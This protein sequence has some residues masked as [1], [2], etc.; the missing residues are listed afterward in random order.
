MKT[1][2][3]MLSL[4]FVSASGWAFPISKNYAE[5]QKFMRDLVSQNP[6]TTQLFTLAQSDSGEMIEGLRIGN[7]PTNNLLV[8]THHGNEY[9]S[10]E[11]AKGFALSLAASPIQ[12]QT[13][14]IIPVLNISGYNARNRYEKGQDPNRD[15]PGPCGTNGPFKLKSTAA[16][17]KFI[18]DKAIIASATLHTYS[19]AVV[20]PWGISTHDLSTPYD[21]LFKGLVKAATIESGYQTGNNTEVMYPADGTFED[22]AFWKTGAWSLLWEV[23]YTHTPSQQQVDDIVKLN[24]PGLRRVFEQTPLARAEKH[25]FTGKCDTAMPK[26]IRLE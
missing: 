26:R 6:S 13:V 10:T 23:G 1:V 25:E 17:A 11:L 3:L 4:F 21:D 20:Y 7:G 19:P 22:Y 8:A 16:L 9:G 5:I 14:W 2:A 12:G 24:V 15:Y 18:E